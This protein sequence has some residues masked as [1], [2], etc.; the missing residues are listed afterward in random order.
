M[1]QASWASAALLCLAFLIASFP[2]LAYVIGEDAIIVEIPFPF[3]VGKQP[4]PAGTYRVGHRVSQFPSIQLDS[5]DGQTKVPL[6][7]IVRMPRDRTADAREAA[8]VFEKVGEKHFLLEVWL[9]GRDGFRMRSPKKGH[10]QV[11][12]DAKTPPATP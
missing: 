1:R 2:A 9:P 8:L 7:A 3:S 11:V 5:L 10:E 12:L 4:F 6:L